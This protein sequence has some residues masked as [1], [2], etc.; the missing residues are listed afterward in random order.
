MKII[1]TH[2]H[3]YPDAIADRASKGIGSFYDYPIARDRRVDTLLA[4]GG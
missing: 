2:C 4:L 1:D 3:V